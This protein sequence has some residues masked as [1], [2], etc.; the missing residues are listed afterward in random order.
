[1]EDLQTSKAV[2]YVINAKPQRTLINTTSHDLKPLAV[3]SLSPFLYT[4][5]MVLYA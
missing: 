5:L 4:V 2:K 1:M 3:S